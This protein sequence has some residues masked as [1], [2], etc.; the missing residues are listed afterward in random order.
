MENKGKVKTSKHMDA[1]CSSPHCTKKK[2]SEGIVKGVTP[3]FDLCA[4]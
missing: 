3:S 1:E 2:P 4:V